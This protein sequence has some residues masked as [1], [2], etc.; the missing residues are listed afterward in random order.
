MKV[1]DL[2]KTPLVAMFLQ[3][4]EELGYPVIDLNGPNNLG[5]GSL[6]YVV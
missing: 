6:Y 3:A 1:S 4:A 2:A 5:E